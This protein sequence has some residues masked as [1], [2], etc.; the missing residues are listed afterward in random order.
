M[1]FIKI[2]DR[3]I[4]DKTKEN[5]SQVPRSRGGNAIKFIVVHYMGVPNRQ[6]FWLYGGGYG[7]HYNIFFDGTIYKSADPKTAILW[8]CGGGLQGS[9]GHSFHGICTNS[10]SIGIECACKYTEDVSDASGDSGKW[11][12]TTETQESIVYLVSKLM[13]EYGI[14]IDHV[15]RHYDV[16]GKICPNPYV[17]NNNL[18][19]SWTWEQFKARLAEYRKSGGYTTGSSAEAPVQETKFYRVRKSWS[20]AGS[21]LGAYTVLANAKANCPTG[22]A[23]F[24]WNGKEIYR[25][26]GKAE[27]TATT[28]LQASTLKGI[29][30]AAVVQK[31]GPLFTADMEKSGI[32]ASVTAAQFIL[33]SGYGQTELAQAANNCFGMKKSLSGN[34]WAGSTWDGKSIYTKKTQ[35]DDGKGNLYTITADFRKYPCV[36]D[37]IG[38]HSAYLLGAKNG[39]ALRYAGL[40]GERD[41]KKAIK[42]IKDGGYATDTKYVSKIC[43]II[44]RWN[45]TAL[46]TAGPVVPSDP[47]PA[48][49]EQI[50]YR[51]R[52]T[53][54]DAASQKGA[55]HV[56]E[57][58]KECADKNPGFC[59]FDESGKCVYESKAKASVPF[60]V[61]VDREDLN[62]RTGPG[63]NYD[64]TQYIPVG[65]YTIVEVQ[66]GKGSK[67]GWGRLKSGAGWISLDYAVKLA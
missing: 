35:E 1:G 4:I 36:E 39:S 21:Q 32:L 8:H 54:A 28:G 65:I 63:T 33:E 10:N 17:K 14:S 49:Q 15:I 25:P 66:D 38:D 61:R 47:E 53:W 30:E 55:F 16:T 40:K 27:E 6:S 34:T 9:G 19:T 23:V 22:Y 42:I 45:L 31:V 26:E 41:Y 13:D 11:Y 48:P 18:R 67:A 64:R 37:S 56:L 12:F 44:E 3:K 62:I 20:D 51:V 29:G 59:V 24:D 5:L 2:A 7:G 58:A 50:W 46:D 52:K 43:S 57:N 60:T